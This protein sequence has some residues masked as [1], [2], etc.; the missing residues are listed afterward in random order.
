ML[1]G[2]GFASE[3][4]ADE[5]RAR[6]FGITGVPFFAIDER[7]G[8]SGAQPPEAFL[9]TLTQAWEEG[10]GPTAAVSTSDAVGDADEGCEGGSCAT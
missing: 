5:A 7:Y 10:A 1:A 4:R 2:S 8:I 9:A 6:D 3:V